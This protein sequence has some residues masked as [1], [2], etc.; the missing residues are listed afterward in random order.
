MN[1]QRLSKEKQLK[2][3]LNELPSLIDSYTGY[4]NSFKD[5]IVKLKKSNLS[6]LN[7]IKLSELFDIKSG[8]SKIIQN[9]TNLNKGDYPVYSANTKENG[10]FGYIKTFDHNTECI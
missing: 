6:K 7:K 5:E 3:T 1:L 4:I 9:Y 2:I 10:I 8:N